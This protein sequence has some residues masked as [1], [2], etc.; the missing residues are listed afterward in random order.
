[1]AQVVVVGNPATVV[2][3]NVSVFVGSI[4][5]VVAVDTLVEY[6]VVLGVSA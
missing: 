6:I 3:V 4:V 2:V 5:L 1:V